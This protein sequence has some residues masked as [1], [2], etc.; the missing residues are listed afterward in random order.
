MKETRLYTLLALLLMAGGLMNAQVRFDW[1]WGYGSMGD[2]VPYFILKTDEGFF[3][4]GN[5]D[6]DGGFNVECEHNDQRGGWLIKLNDDG[7]LV[8]Q[9]C[10]DM[11]ILSQITQSRTNPNHYFLCGID[12]VGNESIPCVIK[13]D[14]QMN[15]LWKR[16]Y[17][18]PA[19]TSPYSPRVTA[20]CDGGCICGHTVAW[21]GGD[22][23]HH[24]G[25][26]DAWIFKLDSLGNLQW[27]ITL[28]TEDNELVN[29]IKEMDDRTYTVLIAG[30]PQSFGSLYSCNQMPGFMF[31]VVAKIDAEGNLLDN[32]C[33]GGYTQND[34][35]ADFIVLEDG[36]LYAGMAASDDGDLEGAGYHLGYIMGVPHYGRSGD[37]WLMKTDFDGNIIWSKCYGGTLNDAACKVFQ[38]EDGGFTVTGWSES[39]NGDVQS[40]LQLY[41]E[42]EG[43]W[44]PQKPW[45]FRTDAEGNL[46]WER[47]MGADVAST[48]YYADAVQVSD[49][50]IV[51]VC[52]DA[53]YPPP[54]PYGD[55]NC[56]NVV[57]GSQDNYWVFHLTDIYDYDGIEEQES[58][59]KDGVKVYPNPG[60]N[61]FNI[62]TTLQNACVEVY[63]MNGRMVHSQEITENVTSINAEGWPSGAYIWKVISDNKEAESGKWIKE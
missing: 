23:S 49:K 36:F 17:G 52:Q 38:N 8:D 40:A 21:D 57:V 51:F 58:C 55:I 56:P 20:T 62:R 16:V 19:Y 9:E 22:I 42:P 26:W 13:M 5:I 41:E 30:S 28:G 33:Y 14:K 60:N 29:K 11:G 25:S 44:G 12:P 1:Q 46:L 37:A 54:Y 45:I 31:G 4:G 15:V 2:D 6:N 3:V 59:P 34:S 18:N 35:F 27:E 48:Q 10:V 43:S 53:L 47:V 63:D 50:E 39:R 24:Y 7:E 32:R 61:T